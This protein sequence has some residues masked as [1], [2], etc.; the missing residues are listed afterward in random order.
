MD[1]KNF[2]GKK[3]KEFR[4]NKGLTQDKLAEKI[5]IDVKHLSRIEC[6]K[7]QLSLNL[8]YKICY[9]LDVEPFRLFDTSITK[10][11]DEM[12]KEII[13]F[14]SETNEDKVRIYYKIL[15]NL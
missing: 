11:K 3:I 7:N 10:Q 13:K 8:L 6:G 15:M 9:I 12:I 14:L 4:K 5:G 2:L 1:N